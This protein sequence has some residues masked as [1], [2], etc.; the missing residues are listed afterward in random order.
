MPQFSVSARTVP[1]LI[2]AIRDARI[3]AGISQAELAQR[4]GATRYWINQFEQGKSPN[5][6]LHRVLALCNALGITLTAEYAVQPS[7][8][9][10]EETAKPTA[11]PAQHTKSPSPTPSPESPSAA[12]PAH[13]AMPDDTMP[14]NTRFNAILESFANRLDHMPNM[15]NHPFRSNERG[16]ADV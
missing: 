4:T 13:N 15:V 11:L 9:A 2:T 7:Q 16:N 3:S 12:S 10:T 6:G 1:Q 8:L 14:D 5:A